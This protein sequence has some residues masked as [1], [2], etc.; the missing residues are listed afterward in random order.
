VV[1]GDDGIMFDLPALLSE[2]LATAGG[3]ET[4]LT[5]GVRPEAV[6]VARE[7]R[8]GYV[9]VEAHIIEPL[10]AY[11]IVDL[12]IG[13]QFLRARTA[14]GFVPRVGEVVWARLDESQIHFFDSSN[15]RSLHVGL[16]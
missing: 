16:S 3:K 11:D 15:G 6:L 7:T 12:K 10:G 13:K 9:P 14:S 2:R 8:P 1:I 5:L 4:E